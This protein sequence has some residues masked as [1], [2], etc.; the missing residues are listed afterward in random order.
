MAPP[1]DHQQ[2]RRDVYVVLSSQKESM[3]RLDRD[4][5]QSRQ[6][7]KTRRK[8][9]VEHATETNGK[10]VALKE[11]V[12]VAVRQRKRSGGAGDLQRAS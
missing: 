9:L 11:V 1:L 7:N 2:K 4:A 8:Q 10:Q 12:A 3:E 5:T 6:S